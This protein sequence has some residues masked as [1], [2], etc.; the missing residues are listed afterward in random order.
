M[1]TIQL[2]ARNG[3]AVREAIELG[4]IVHMATASEELTDEFMLFAIKSGVLQEWAQGFPDPR[5]DAESG[6]EVII[7][8]AL[9]AR[10]AG[11][12]SLR[13]MGYV[14]QS[15]RV[16]GELGYSVEVI[17]AGK[18][19]SRRGTG[20]EQVISGDVLRQL[21][22][23]MEQHITRSTDALAGEV[24]DTRVGRVRERG[25]RRAVKGQVDG[26]E[27]QARGR[28]VGEQLTEWY[29]QCVGASLLAYA[30]VGAGRR[31]HIVDC[32]KV[33]VPRDSGHDEC[34]GGV[35]NDDGSLA[36]GYKLATIRT[37][38]D[39]AGVFT[40]AAV[41]PIQVHEVEVCRS[42][43]LTS[44]ALRVGDLLLEDNGLMDGALI[45]ALKRTRQVDVIVPLRSTM[46]AFDDAVRLA[47]MTG[48]WQPHPSRA[49]QQI[50]FV[51]GVHHVWDTCSVPLNACVIR[52]WHTKKHRYAYMVVVTTDQKLTTKWIVKHDEQRPEIEQD[53]EQMKSGGWKLQKLS[54]TRYSAI[55]FYLV[56]VL[57]SYSLYHLF[58]NTS[59]GT[60]FA[61]KTRQALVLEQLQTQ[62]TH[63]I[64]YAG[65]YFEIFETL[66]FVRLVLD[67][68]PLIQA[69]LRLWLD[70]HLTHSEKPA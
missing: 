64:V 70:E 3:D 12:Y 34:S 9:A 55:V 17:E 41:A 21:L 26:R 22:V 51:P 13:Q 6:M 15:A 61:N 25:S 19:I 62:R 69:R 56:S 10:F 37:L 20:D 16:L 60:H 50:A 23:Q 30:Q 67:L 29:T 63:I 5:K 45:S 59:A 58:A 27:A 53:D 66:T 52:Y 11:I 36:R 31:L 43:L 46:V 44:P 33:E 42:M 68:P 32:T 28:G 24:V 1:D 7:A 8:T 54:S 39:T 47:E 57:L 49:A 38:L 48:K 2:I 18:G 35:K 4:D 14:L 40:Q 65:G